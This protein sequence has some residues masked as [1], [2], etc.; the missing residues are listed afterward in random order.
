MYR[1]TDPDDLLGKAYDS[2]VARRLVAQV[3]PYRRSAL[4]ALGLVLL[5][6]LFELAIPYLFGLAVDV[7][8]DAIDGTSGRG[9]LGRTGGDALN[10][11]GIAF[12]AVLLLR[13]VARYFEMFLM[14][15]VGQRI[16]YDLRSSMFAHIQRLGIRY[17]DRRG[18]GSIMSRLQNDVSVID[19]LFADGLVDI[20]SQVALLVGI[21]IL[22][23]LTNWQLALVAFA[24]LPL[25]VVMMR[26][27]RRR[28][29]LTYR[30]TRITIGRVNGFLAE[31]IAGMRVIQ[32][33]TREPRNLARFT[34][35][36]DENLDANLDAARLSAFL[37]PFVTFVEYVTIALVLYVGGRMVG[38]VAF[39]VGELVTFVA[40]VGRFYEPI[41]QLSQ[42]YNT[43]QAATAAGERIY[44]IL[45]AEPEITDAPGAVDLPRIKG[46]VVF[47]RVRFGYDEVEVLHDINLEVQPGESI[48][49]VGETGAGKS[50]MI[51]LLTRF[52]DVRDGAIRIDGYD[53]RDVTQQSLRSQLGVVPQ[54]TFLFAGSIRDNILFAR[55]DATE[56]EMVA[57]A[58]A[59]GA[60]EFIVD[61]P[62]GYDAEVHERGATLSVGQRQLIS[63]ARA[64]ISNPRIIILDEATSSVDTETELVI[65]AA[66]RR[67]LAGRTS[68]IIAHRLS[69]TRESSRVVVLDHGRI[70]EVGSHDDLLDRQGAYHKLYTM[71]FRAAAAAD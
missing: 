9:F 23:W 53:I 64:L 28:A 51:N 47:D 63:F 44:S 25:M 30:Q 11:L 36:N 3:R 34:D 32:S 21:I 66:L 33:F 2:R 35:I 18:V 17:I 61:L 22:M 20:L 45:D 27:W 7:V 46:H 43:L 52:Y 15:Q 29:I 12:V 41:N 40:Y 49:F 37:F 69:T 10:A 55:P 67:L 56:D 1:A 16:V 19:Q 68:F 62:G 13:F 50:S 38:G 57:A 58:K 70:V 48:A 42:A 59:V 8:R 31:N 26:F 14:G 24:L 65:Q 5:V 60:H 39:T 4:I 54:D 71:Q 6:T